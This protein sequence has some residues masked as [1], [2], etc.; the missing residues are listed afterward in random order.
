VSQPYKPL[1][2]QWTL[3]ENTTK[4]VPMLKDWSGA[5]NK[6]GAVKEPEPGYP[7]DLSS[8]VDPHVKGALDAMRRAALRAREI[9]RQTGTD[10]ILVRDGRVVHVKP[11]E[12]PFD[13]CGPVLS[14]H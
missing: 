7:G 5:N 11:S 12:L 3:Y 2:D 14:L 8:Q 6:P 10:L 9:A 4:G 1:V 13:E